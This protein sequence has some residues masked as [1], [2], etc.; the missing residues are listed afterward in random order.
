MLNT[1]ATGKSILIEP[2]CRGKEGQRDEWS[3]EG[4]GRE[5]DRKED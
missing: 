3:M 1:V 5:T 4:R 2:E